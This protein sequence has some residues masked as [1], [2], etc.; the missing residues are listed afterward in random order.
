MKE[1]I[2]L[3]NIERTEEIQAI[4]DRMPTKFGIWITGFVLA[5]TVL[6][7]VF[8]WSIRYPD[9][10]IGQIVMNANSSPV[11]LVAYTGGKLYLI[12]K[13]QSHV[14]EGDYIAYVEN[15]ANLSDIQNTY[16]LIK[17][18]N[19]NNLGVQVDFPRNVSLG[20]LNTKYFSF[21]NAYD[22]LL[23]HNQ[24]D[25][26]LRQGEILG[27][28]LIEQQNTLEIYTK[29]LSLS[30]ENVRLM[31][32]FHKRDSTLFR[33]KVMSEAEIDKSDMAFLSVKDS[34]NNML[35]E[36]TTVKEQ[37][38]E[39]R[40]K[41]QQ[42]SIQKSQEKG[43]SHLNL[44]TTYTDLVD[45]FKLWEQ[46]YVFKSPIKGIVQ[47]SRFWNNGEFLQAGEPVFTIVPVK[48][49]VLGQMT[50]PSS[51]AGKVRVGQEVI[52][53]LDNYPYREY[54]SIK[55]KVL[56]I[57]L[58]TNTVKTEKGE[59]ETY[60]VNVD[61]PDELKTNYGSKLDFKYE[62]KGTGEIITRDR[63]LIERLFDNMKYSVNK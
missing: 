63:K 62:I 38:Q 52:I 49:K 39:T 1:G 35:N 4:I 54:G 10:I 11:K 14:N 47:F 43:K 26:L 16:K 29:K 2:T 9:I 30:L 7:F 27:K 24:A 46:K 36:I 61:L 13:A 44:V 8:G 57:S 45:N 48:S 33:N 3:K 5:L 40:S 42:N 28:T 18:L 55:G 15:S 50:L 32:K 12:K 21:I 6:F 59:A 22:D 20:D 41:I 23:N 31:I 34:Y 25:L 37:I 17:K 56:S 19:V 60:L 53:K 51:G 58:T